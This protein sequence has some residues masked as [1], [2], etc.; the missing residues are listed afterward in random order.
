V[1][2][3]CGGV[4]REPCAGAVWVDGVKAYTGT[5]E[6]SGRGGGGKAR[7]RRRT[8]MGKLWQHGGKGDVGWVN[9]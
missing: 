1:Q 8:G 3:M 7:G 6:G 9:G 4:G 5:C 2:P